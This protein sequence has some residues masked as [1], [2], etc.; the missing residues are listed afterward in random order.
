MNGVSYI[1]VTYATQVT[2]DNPNQPRGRYGYKPLSAYDFEEFESAL[3]LVDLATGR[4][5]HAELWM[6]S[7]EHGWYRILFAQNYKH[8]TAAVRI[9]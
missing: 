8:E 7:T 6:Y 3:E 2:H 5:L 1:V 4:G 9:G